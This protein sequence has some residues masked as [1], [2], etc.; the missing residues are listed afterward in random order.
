MPLV[1][2]TALCDNCKIVRSVVEVKLVCES[3]AREKS[4]A[5]NY[6]DELPYNWPLCHGEFMSF[7]RHSRCPNCGDELKEHFPNGR[8]PLDWLPGTYNK[9]VFI[10]GNYESISNLRD[11]KNA[12]HELGP[13]FVPILPYDDFQIPKGQVYDTDLRLLHN[14]KYAIFEVTRPGG[15]LFEIA[16]CAEYRV[17]TLLVYQ[18][19]GFMNAPPNVKTMLLESGSHEHRSYLTTGQL[20]LV[21][22]EFLR[23]KNPTQWQRAINLM[24]YHF[25]EYSVHNKLYLNGEA[26]HSCSLIG[27]KV[28]IPDLRVSEITHDFRITS[29]HIVEDTFKLDG[30]DY[31]EWCRDNSTSGEQAEVGVV[32]FSPPLDDHSNITTYNFNLKTQNSYML[33]KK[34]L[35]ELLPEGTD[36]PFLASGREFAS[37]DIPFPLEKFR[38]HVE[39]PTG[40][41]VNP[42]PA[43]YFGTEPRHEGLKMPPDSYSFDGSNA[44]LEVRRPLIYHRYAIT[45]E[46]PSHLPRT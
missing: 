12:V 44:I 43:V 13:D 3:C 27:L 9:R 8:L 25:D 30:P 5:E 24:G 16:R 17:T 41:Q 37:K 14:C 46:L 22:D 42:Q 6:L 38:L 26:E 36:D 29:G 20:R 4:V 19:R 35:S 39:F 40:Y 15:E 32:R 10:G 11:I 21:V 18:A 23:Q 33:T 2:K 7:M 1:P 45:W 34:Q 28:D 31:V